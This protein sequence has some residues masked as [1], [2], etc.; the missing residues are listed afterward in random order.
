MIITYVRRRL[1]RNPGQTL[2]LIVLGGIFILSLLKLN[3]TLAVQEKN[4]QEMLPNISIR[5]AV[6]DHRGEKTDGLSITSFII[7]SCTREESP[8]FQYV[9]K[10]AIKATFGFEIP[11]LAHDPMLLEEMKMKERSIVAL[12]RLDA[13]RR[14]DELHG[15]EIA[16]LPG[17]D[18]QCFQETT[19]YLCLLPWDIYTLILEKSGEEPEDSWIPLNVQ[20][21]DSVTVNL[22]LDAGSSGVTS[23]GY[24][25]QIAGY[26]R[27]GT[28]DVYCNWQV[29]LDGFSQIGKPYI[30]DSL[31][32]VL[33]DN[34][35]LDEFREVSSG[36]FGPV[37]PNPSGA[38]AGLSLIV[39]DQQYNAVLFSIDRS[40][41]ML[42]LVLPLLYALAVGIG[43]FV[44]YIAIRNRKHEFALMASLGTGRAKM[45]ILVFFELALLLVIGI[46][47]G[48]A[49]HIGTG[50]QVVLE[51]VL[52]HNLVFILCFMAGAAAAI[53]RVLSPNVISMLTKE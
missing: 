14:L 13:E 9:D 42:Q 34:S 52:T 20:Q 33:R 37:G 28:G 5:C 27:G 4:R 1:Q 12:T 30:A 7:D 23:V 21:G 48:T 53:V 39:H 45:F 50:N 41:K 17:N 6:T 8:L 25:M 29:A 18:E 49:F 32:F 15:V 36:Y 22:L 35:R 16:F 40:I 47:M 3:S 31:S 10:V 44:S 2:T 19:R 24:D 43:F 26:Y 51:K 46:S 11:C 38:F